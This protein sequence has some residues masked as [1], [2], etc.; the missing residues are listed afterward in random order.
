MERL[1]EVLSIESFSPADIDISFIRET[2][3]QVSMLMNVSPEHARELATKFLAAL[4]IC[5]R[6]YAR[7]TRW[8]GKKKQE[9]KREQSEAMLMR[10]QQ[11]TVSGQSADSMMDDDYNR[12]V[13]EF[14]EAN[15]YLIFFMQ[16]I[17]FFKMAHYWA[18]MNVGMSHDESFTAGFERN[19][20]DRFSQTSVSQVSTSK[21]ISSKTTDFVEPIEQNL[22]SGTIGW[23][24]IPPKKKK[25]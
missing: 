11:K 18:K 12:K 3:T 15:A 1:G 23:D 24:S 14:E 19:D 7:L 13:E 8:V 5:S 6:E 20:I 4:D 22:S 2:S 10:S 16:Y 17:E 25:E 9:M 21:A